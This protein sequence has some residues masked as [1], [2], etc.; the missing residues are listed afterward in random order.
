MAL[1]IPLS[2][3]QYVSHHKVRGQVLAVAVCD[4]CAPS[5]FTPPAVG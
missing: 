4:N 1:P 3:L 2:F 5:T